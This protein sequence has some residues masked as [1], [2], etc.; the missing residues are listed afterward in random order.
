MGR[1]SRP[2]AH[3]FARFA[4]VA[5]GE[6]VLDVGCGTGALTKV[7]AEL[8]GAENVAGVDPSEPFVSDQSAAVA[9]M[10]RVTQP[11]G[12]WLRAFGTSPAG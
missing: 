4:A 5:P 9:E 10:A 8:I 6:H 2:L 1:Y 3:E 12:R 7:L 11:G